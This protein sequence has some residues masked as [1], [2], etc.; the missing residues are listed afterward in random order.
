MLEFGAKTPAAQA[1]ATPLVKDTTE[2][3]FMAK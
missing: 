1:P 2:A 3:G